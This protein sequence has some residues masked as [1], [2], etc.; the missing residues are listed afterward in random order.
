MCYN[1][2]NKTRYQ[3]IEGESLEKKTEENLLVNLPK[4]ARGQETLQRICQAA[5]EIFN[6]KGYYETSIND[7]TRRARVSAGTFYIYFD[8]KYALYKYLLSQY[9]RRIRRHI[10]M[11]I[12]GCRTR[13]EAE[14]EGLRAWLGFVAEHKYVFNITWESLFIDKTLFDDYYANFSAAYVEQLKKAQEKGEVLDIDPEVLS[15][16]LMGISNFI[17]LHWVVFKEER[18]VDYVVDEAM[19][20]IDGI[21]PPEK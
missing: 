17:G 20:I 11:S 15:F 1:S 12:S 9:G 21:F 2:R 7:I 19:K 10:S 13:R 8:S 14:R 3:S 5:E 16:A 18:D 4:T 6:G